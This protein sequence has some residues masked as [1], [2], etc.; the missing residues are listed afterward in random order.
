MTKKRAIETTVM[1]EDRGMVVLGGLI[2]DDLI[3][4][5]N[6][7]PI[8]GDIPIIG[9]LFKSSKVE[10]K[11]AN[12]MVFIRPTI[13]KN[14]VLANKLAMEKYQFLRTKQQ[15]MQ[16]EGVRLIKSKEIPVLPEYKSSDSSGVILPKPFSSQ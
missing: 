5:V 12:L 14:P 7:V 1:V 15:E 16:Q 13:I 11:K 8:L 2:Q 6:K 9:E 3:N 4:N 10:T